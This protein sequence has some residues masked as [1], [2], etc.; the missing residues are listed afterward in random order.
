MNSSI[1]IVNIEDQTAWTSFFNEAGSPTFL[2]SWEWAELQQTLGYRVLRLGIQSDHLIGIALCIMIKSR[3]GN[4]LFL[5][6]GPIISQKSGARNNEII[7]ALL[8]YLKQAA[9]ENRCD[10]IRIAPILKDTEENR[11]IFSKSGLINAPTYMH[12]ERIWVLPLNTDENTLLT[13]MRKTTRYSIRKAQKIGIR[14]KKRT[15]IHAVDEFWYL[16]T[17]TAKREGFVPFSKQFITDEYTEFH[18]N[19]NAAFFFAYEEDRC[20]ASAL[21]IFTRSTAFYHQGATLHSK[22]PTSYLLQWR[23]ICEAKKR[24][25]QFYNFWGTYQEKRTPEDWK[26]LSL[27]KEG[28]GGFQVDYIQTQDL[29]LSPKYYISCLYDIYLKWKRG[30]RLM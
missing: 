23:A 4:F 24:G 13:H 17:Q 8:S 28:F 30:V 15:D 2:Q 11:M 16:Y 1:R 25:C 27:F 3:R 29:I 12:A 18:K 26:G 6:H 9:K 7:T 14:V 19:G 10:F 5:P 21:I 20:T 22:L